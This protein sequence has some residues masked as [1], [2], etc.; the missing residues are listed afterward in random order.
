MPHPSLDIGVECV[1]H[2]LVAV[3]FLKAS[4]NLITIRLDVV[5]S[6]LVGVWRRDIMCV[7]TQ[8][9]NKVGEGAARVEGE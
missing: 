2:D 3:G 9:G 6:C 8:D 5:S 4:R 1:N 7:A